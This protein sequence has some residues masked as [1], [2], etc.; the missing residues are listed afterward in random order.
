M[1]PRRALLGLACAVVLACGTNVDLGGTGLLDGETAD[2]PNCPG[3]AAPNTPA[4]C[5]ARMGSLQPNGCFGGYYCRLKDTDCQPEKVAC[6][7]AD[8]GRGG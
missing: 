2:G 8:A 7:V 3:F 4:M 1:A 5:N 6:G